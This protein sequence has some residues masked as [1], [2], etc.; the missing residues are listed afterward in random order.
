MVLT[1]G[2]AATYF[3]YEGTII[4]D[5]GDSDSHF[6]SDGDTVYI[7]YAFDYSV[8]DTYP[9]DPNY[10]L[11][12]DATASLRFYHVESGF[13]AH[14]TGGNT[15]VLMNQNPDGNPARSDDGIFIFG[16]TPLNN[17][18]LGDNAVGS[19]SLEAVGDSSMFDKDKLPDGPIDL[20]MSNLELNFSSSYD[21]IILYMDLE[22]VSQ[23]PFDIQ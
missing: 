14:F 18:E 15:S 2:L 10:G 16:S 21:Y 3:I 13:E 9:D 19:L 23:G 11:Y 7:T 5:Q 22:F 17:P 1:Q 20:S 8:K 4:I 12:P 6:F